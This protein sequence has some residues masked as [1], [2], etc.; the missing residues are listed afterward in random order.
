MQ[1]GGAVGDVLALYR[2]ADV[3]DARRFVLIDAL[4]LFTPRGSLLERRREVRRNPLFRAEAKR[5]ARLYAQSSF[6][7]GRDG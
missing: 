6:P 7:G 3:Q 2:A 4:S 1:H 5:M